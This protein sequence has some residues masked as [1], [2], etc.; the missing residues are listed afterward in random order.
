[1]RLLS[2]ALVLTL[3]APG[4][5]A[6][7]QPA[8]RPIT[9]ED[10]WLMKRVGSPELSPDGR[11]VVVA[12]SQPAYDEAQKSSDLWLMPADGS[13]PPRQLTFTA[14]AESGPAW[15]PD[16]R[17]IAFAA[18]REGQ[19]ESQIWVL[20]IAGGGEA[21][22]VTNV[23]TG[24]TRPQW[25]PDG[26]AILFASMVY[27]GA[28]NDADNRARIEERKARKY[29]A[30]AYDEFPIRHWDRWLDERQP[31]LMLQPLAPGAEAFDLLAGTE[32]AKGRGFGGDL[33]NEGE[34]LD[35]AW[36]PDGSAIVF[37]ATTDR[38]QAARALV[39]QSLFVV[40]AG[41]GEPRRLTAAEAS[42]SNPQFAPDGSAL[43]ARQTP[44]TR[45]VYN[46]A[47]L[48]RFDWGN[49]SPR[50]VAFNF[51]RSVSR[52]RVAPDGERVFLIAED[53]GHDRVFVVPATGGDVR[54]LGRLEAGAFAGLAVEGTGE[55]PVL[56][57]NW[58]SAVSPPEVHRIDPATGARTALSAFN[59]ER[60]AAIDWQ[61]VQQFW[62]TS[63]RGRRIHNLIAL[64][65]DFDA[66]RK[67]PLFV[68]IHGGPHGAFGDQFIFRWNYHLLAQPGY[69]VLM[70]NYTGSTGFG[71]E[72]AQGIQGDPLEGPAAEINQA[73]DE[74]IRR[75]PF[76]DASRQA[77][78]GASYGGHL[79][80]WLAVSTT[81]YRAL[82][83][84]AGLY[85]LKTQWTTSDIA[86][87][88][89]RNLGGPAWEDRPVWRRQSPFWH[90]TKLKTPILVTFGER[91]F[92]VPYNNGLEFWTVLQRQQV[93][94]RLVIFPDENHWIL[95]G[96]NSRYFYQEVQGWL[97]RHLAAP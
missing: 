75:Y 28:M 8:R 43:Y 85:D 35:A 26:E 14:G 53:E 67:Y 31:T 83:S 10:V 12:V 87:S 21:A 5:V 45:F 49:P 33:G 66:S 15:S 54:E 29:N 92:R 42:Y 59:A 73:A 71:E 17:R 86:W 11:W 37:T 44:R 2:L 27:P 68:L 81:R 3:A 9:H 57:A 61:P 50:P 78:G 34:T 63:K 58:G 74:A 95:K 97:A 38:D 60:V 32:L 23:S 40:P 13:A 46:D 22:R 88:R 19:D 69:V 39:Q 20:D 56:V 70:T 91:D 36:S 7:D 90:S 24:A 77:A 72:F 64:P 94:S 48:V 47:R 25:R 84:H 76:I 65:P 51:H 79:A 80:N 18:K 4:A 93:E 82:V 41:G 62:F 89:E 16:S 52:F 6:A 30:R 55:T 1:M 96:E